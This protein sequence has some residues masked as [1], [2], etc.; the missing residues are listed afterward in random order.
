MARSRCV[1]GRP[2][3]RL[4]ALN[5]SAV[6]GLTPCQVN[7]KGR[8][9]ENGDSPPEEGGLEEGDSPPKERGPEEGDSPPK[10]RGLSPCSQISKD[11]LGAR[12]PRL[13][14]SWARTLRPGCCGSAATNHTQ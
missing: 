14:L 10:E 3:P 13:F 2:R 4:R 1:A 9:V 6:C 8:L 7:F 11:R 12:A 5:C